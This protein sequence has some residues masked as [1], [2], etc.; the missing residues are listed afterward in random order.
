MVEI[1]AEVSELEI[2]WLCYARICK[3]YS[4][5]EQNS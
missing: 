5:A 3:L 1:A 4:L 2:S